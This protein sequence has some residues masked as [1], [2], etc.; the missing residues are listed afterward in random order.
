MARNQRDGGSP[1]S[2]SQTIIRTTSNPTA[3]SRGLMCLKRIP[4]LAYPPRRQ[5][6]KP[7]RECK[8]YLCDS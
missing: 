4:H 6:R 5:A 8:R 7:R 2:S 1:A 3:P